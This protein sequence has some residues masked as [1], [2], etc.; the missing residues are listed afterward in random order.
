MNAA[1]TLGIIGGGQ[2]ARM[3]AAPALGL[4]L[5]LRLL[6]EGAQTSAAQVI[7][8]TTVGDYTD[9]DAV[10]AWASGLTAV[11]FDHEHVPDAVLRALVAHGVEARPGPDALVFASDKAAMRAQLTE[12]GMPCPAWRVVHNPAELAE[13]AAEH[14]W[15]VVAK[16]SRGGYDGKGVWI[17][18]SVADAKAPFDS[19]AVGHGPTER[20]GSSP[21]TSAVIVAEEYVRFVRELSVLVVR[22]ADGEVCH[23]DISETVQRD[24]VCRETITPAPGLDTQR[25]DE[26]YA[27]ATELARACGVVG[28]LAV[29][30]MEAP[31]G[32][33]LVNELAMRPHNTGHWT[34]D[35]A[36][37]S[38][39]ENHIRAAAGLPLGPTGLRA[40][41]VVMTNVLGG[42]VSDLAGELGAVLTRFPEARVQLYGKS[43]APGRKVGHVTAYGDSLEV[44]RDTARGAA[45]ML[46]GRGTASEEEGR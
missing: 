13:F 2:L 37:T 6:A 27:F 33:I 14:G 4:G 21:Q 45:A 38:Q 36:H 41:H 17:V 8:A 30:L 7:P 39:F 22:G 12:W 18:D 1:S 31:D 11:T 3:M 19:L 42:S 35:G 20:V 26:V 28:V 46:E 9:A 29:E 32:R 16:V 34:I 5:P 24:G 44:A 40:P 15:P 43:V 10:V 23:Y 25:A